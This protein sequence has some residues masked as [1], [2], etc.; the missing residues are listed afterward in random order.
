MYND[1]KRYIMVLEMIGEEIKGIRKGLIEAVATKVVDPVTTGTVK[2]IKPPLAVLGKRR[3]MIIQ[4]GRNI[5]LKPLGEL[6]KEIGN[7]K[8]KR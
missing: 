7:I 3:N 2:V 1:N 6:S 4:K 8:I 5:L